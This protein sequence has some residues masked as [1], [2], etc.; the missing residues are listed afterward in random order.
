[1]YFSLLS[2]IQMVALVQILILQLVLVFPWKDWIL[3]LL[4]SLVVYVLM[5]VVVVSVK[6][7]LLIYKN[8]NAL[9]RTHNNA[10]TASMGIL[11]LL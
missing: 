11:S 1:M 5:L 8:L 6:V 2:L 9:M 3:R 7:F 10:P 4:E